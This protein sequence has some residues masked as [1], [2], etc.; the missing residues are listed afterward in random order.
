MSL[1]FLGGRG[2]PPPPSFTLV[3]YNSGGDRLLW[4][5]VGQQQ[6]A[7]WVHSPQGQTV[8]RLPGR[9]VSYVR[10]TISAH[11]LLGM[12]RPSYVNAVLIQSRGMDHRR[13]CSACRGG[14]GFR[15]FPE[16]R[17]LPGHF[18]GACGNCKWRDHASR[19]SVRD[20]DSEGTTIDH[21]S[22]SDEDVVEVRR[23]W[24]LPAATGAGSPVVRSRARP[25]LPEDG[26]EEI[27]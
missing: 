21:T 22:D 25:I 13:P 27:D 18:G 7:P 26:I 16:C 20:T 5:P 15:P 12:H 19:C 1:S 14:A 3:P 11:Q 2:P 8:L 6:L 17:R 24:A 4:L 10:G 23:G 9:D